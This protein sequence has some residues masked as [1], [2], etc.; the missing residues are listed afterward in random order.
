MLYRQQIR[1]LRPLSEPQPSN[2]QIARDGRNGQVLHVEDNKTLTGI[3]LRIP[4][5]KTGTWKTYDHFDGLA[6]NRVV[7][8]HRAVG[9]IMWFGTN[10]SVSR[11]DGQTFVNFTTADGLPANSVTTIR[12]SPDGTMWFGTDGGLSRRVY[13]SKGSGDPPEERRDGQI[14]VNFT[15]NDGLAGNFVNATDRSPDGTMWFGTNGGVSHYDGNGFVSFTT[16][17]GLANN[18]VYGIEGSPDGTM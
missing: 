6:A 4:A 10:R 14:F 2:S 7:V 1:L 11:Y 3:D 18:A 8:S 16:Q 13:P 15:T 9:G 17:D 12:P 5:F